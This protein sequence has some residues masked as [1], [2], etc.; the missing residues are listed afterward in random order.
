MFRGRLLVLISPS[1]GLS[2]K[3]LGEVWMDIHELVWV[4]IGVFQLLIRCVFHFISTIYGCELRLLGRL[5]VT[6]SPFLSIPFEFT[7]FGFTYP[8]SLSSPVPQ[9]LFGHAL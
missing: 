6:N 1:L 7:C 2:Q 3:V 5:P 8:I 9:F 4:H